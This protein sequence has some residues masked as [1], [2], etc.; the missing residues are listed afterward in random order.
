M[1][2]SLYSKIFFHMVILKILAFAEL[3]T[4][5][6]DLTTDMSSTIPYLEFENYAMRSLFPGIDTHPIM[7]RDVCL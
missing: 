6:T 2:S 3:Q 7:D 5:M 1:L 4:E